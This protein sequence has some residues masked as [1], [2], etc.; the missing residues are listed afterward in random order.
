MGLD[1]AG[2]RPHVAPDRLKVLLGQAAA[3]QVLGSKR[4]GKPPW[5]VKS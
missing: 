1:G 5:T 2:E 4:R 3:W